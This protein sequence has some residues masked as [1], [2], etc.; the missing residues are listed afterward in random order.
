MRSGTGG[1]CCHCGRTSSPCWRKGPPEKPTLCNAC[2]A[3][4]LVK[5]NLDGYMP[6]NK[7]GTTRD[8]LNEA[9]SKVA[10]GS[11]HGNGVTHGLASDAQKKKKAIAK[12]LAED[13]LRPAP[14]AANFHHNHAPPL[15]RDS[16]SAHN[17]LVCQLPAAN[18]VVDRAV[19]T[20]IAFDSLSDSSYTVTKQFFSITRPDVKSED[21]FNNLA[22]STLACMRTTPGSSTESTSTTLTVKPKI[23]IVKNRRKP[24]KPTYRTLF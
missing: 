23:P 4:Y 19:K 2:G 15:F 22:V 10:L 18:F 14:I 11:S 8:G 6:G 7:L 5:R 17:G 3:R 1:P 9:S 13:L 12:R 20:T 21:D 24:P 16:K